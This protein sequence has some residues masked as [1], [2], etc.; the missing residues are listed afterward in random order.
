MITTKNTG[1]RVCLTAITVLTLLFSAGQAMGQKIEMPDI[2]ASEIDSINVNPI[3]RAELDS[4][5]I[6][7]PKKYKETDLLL[8][9]KITIVHTDKNGTKKKDV[10]YPEAKKAEPAAFYKAF[11]DENGEAIKATDIVSIEVLSPTQDEIDALKKADRKKYK[12][13]TVNSIAK[14]KIVY[15]GNGTEKVK[16][17]YQE[18]TNN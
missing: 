16:T 12:K 3:T 4:L 1:K 6:A 5:K 17:E 9:S 7:D 11:T 8:Y 14:V 18:R 2:D 13:A 10:I 15:R